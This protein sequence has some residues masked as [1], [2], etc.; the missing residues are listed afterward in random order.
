MSVPEQIRVWEKDAGVI[1]VRACYGR[2]A[3]RV[4]AKG[5]K[6]K[7]CASSVKKFGVKRAGDFSK[8]DRS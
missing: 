4:I 5:V 7:S 6:A 1:D 3:V 2:R 8:R